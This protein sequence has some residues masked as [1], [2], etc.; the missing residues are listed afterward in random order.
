MILYS[1]HDAGTDLDSSERHLLGA[2]AHDAE[3]AYAQIECEKLRS[4]WRCWKASSRRPLS[5]ADP[6]GAK[7]ALHR[8]AIA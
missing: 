6:A 4:G 2:L 5:L 7:P 1:G 8:E 3:I